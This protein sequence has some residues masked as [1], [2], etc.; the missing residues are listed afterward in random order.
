MNRQ[1]QVGPNGP[2]PLSLQDIH[3]VC[4]LRGV[5]RSDDIEL[6]L[7]VLPELDGMVL[8]QHYDEVEANMKKAN[9]KTPPNRR[10]R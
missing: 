4:K 8:K 9:K 7:I 3:A 10:S 1:R 5:T 6:L 2:Q